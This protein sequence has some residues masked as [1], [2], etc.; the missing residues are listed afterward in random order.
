MAAFF[1]YICLRNGRKVDGKAFS[2]S[3]FGFLEER[4]AE[5]VFCCRFT[6]GLDLKD[7]IQVW[8]PP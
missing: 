7:A 3:F 1:Y 6:G 2:C 8:V 4:E 5:W